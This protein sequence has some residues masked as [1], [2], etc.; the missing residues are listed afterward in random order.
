MIVHTWVGKALT[1]K[2]FLTKQKVNKKQNVFQSEG[3]KFCQKAEVE[4]SIFLVNR[5]EV[6]EQMEM[7]SVFT[8]VLH[9]SNLSRPEHFQVR[10][11]SQT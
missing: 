4:T 5:K 9:V 7:L 3:V 10:V 2:F 6:L 8:D 11:K 1:G